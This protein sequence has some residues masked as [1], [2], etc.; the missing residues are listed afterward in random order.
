MSWV[1][2]S[3]GI[4]QRSMLGRSLFIIYVSYNEP[5]RTVKQYFFAREVTV[6]DIN[7]SEFPVR[8]F[9]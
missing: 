8:K 4:P 9:G 5:A 1:S 7:S 3:C 6:A 2:N